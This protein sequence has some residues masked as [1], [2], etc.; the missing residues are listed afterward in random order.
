MNVHE[1]I[2]QACAAVGIKPPRSYRHGGWTKTDTLNGRNGK[3]D[4]R[5]IVDDLKATA[6]N[7]QTGDKETVWLK[8]KPSPAEM[9]EANVKREKDERE[10]KERAAAAALIAAKLVGASDHG[11]HPYL[12]RKG[13][14]DETALVIP[15]RDVRQI[16]GRT[17]DYGRFIPA[18]YLVPNDGHTAI[19]VPARIGNVVRSVQLIWE[20]GTKKF[21]FAA[22]MGGASHRM[23]TGRD[24][25]L[26]EGYA[27]GLSLRFGLRA[28]NRADTVLC[29][30]SA[31]NIATVA[32]KIEG[33]CFVCADNDKPIE[34]FGNKGTGEHYA[35][36]AGKPYLLPPLIGQDLNDL[37]MTEGRFAVQRVLSEFLRRAS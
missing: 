2:E 34:H 5:V 23:A 9:R 13:F 32:R 24:T 36:E 20:D 33:R 17:D 14:P 8:D 25:W 19:V 28:L 1:A 35:I 16:A 37:H 26:C 27:T 29:C 10:R 7:W 15:A 18:D 31:S 30:F 11:K 3:G 12:S 21:L 4:G 6:W 22:E